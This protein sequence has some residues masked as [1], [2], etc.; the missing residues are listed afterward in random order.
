MPD[1]GIRHVGVRINKAG[2]HRGSPQ[3]SP[4][5]AR[6]CQ[7]HHISARAIREDA[8]AR[9]RQSL[10]RLQIRTRIDPPIE[11]QMIRPQ[12]LRGNR[13]RGRGKK[14][15]PAFHWDSF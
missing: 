9:E 14:K 10:E 1:A 6:G 13:A 8:I 11:Q 4:L 2:Q 7:S 5:H 15:V 3:V 12:C